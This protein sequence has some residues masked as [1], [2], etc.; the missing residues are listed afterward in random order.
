[1]A[2]IFDNLDV[3]DEVES[4]TE[5]KTPIVT[6]VLKGASRAAGI[7]LGTMNAPLAAVWGSLTPYDKPEEQTEFEKLS[8]P[9]KMA[10]RVGS[11]LSSAWESA[12]KEGSFGKGAGSYYE[13]VTG[14]KPSPVYDLVFNTLSDPVIIRGLATGLARGGFQTV[15]E[16]KNYLKSGKK[17]N[18]KG[19]DGV[20]LRRIKKKFCQVSS[21]FFLIF[22]FLVFPIIPL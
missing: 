18:K 17:R 15:K 10:V 13:S 2:D 11:G 4:S 12:T 6:R 21:D 5:E 1:M 19:G 7:A 9:E 8:F 14:E 3:F 22:L 20:G 16:I